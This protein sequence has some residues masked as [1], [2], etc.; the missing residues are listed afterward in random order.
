MHIK[1]TL[2]YNFDEEKESFPVQYI[3]LGHPEFRQLFKGKSEKKN[4]KDYFWKNL[5]RKYFAST[6]RCSGIG[7]W[8]FIV[9]M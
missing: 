3:Y 4:N 2:R 9:H 5:S 7:E 8:D 6:E 1:I